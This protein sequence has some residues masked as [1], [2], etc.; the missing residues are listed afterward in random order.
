MGL[1]GGNVLTTYILKTCELDI[2]MFDP[3]IGIWS[4]V[5]G[6]VIT[7]FFAIIVNIV[8]T[9]SRVKDRYDRKF[10]ECRVN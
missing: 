3:E 10:K 7:I 4:Y 1:L 9:R 8:N 5:L 6:V 2:T